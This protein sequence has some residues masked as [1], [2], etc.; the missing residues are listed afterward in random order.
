MSRIFLAFH[1]FRYFLTVSGVGNIMR[2]I[3]LR[4]DLLDEEQHYIVALQATTPGSFIGYSNVTVLVS[5]PPYAGTCS[6]STPSIIGL[7]H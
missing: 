2:R 7:L 4:S 1:E 5:G 3:T 6:V